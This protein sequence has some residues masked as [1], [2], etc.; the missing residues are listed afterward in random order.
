MRPVL[1]R[2][3]EGTATVVLRRAAPAWYWLRK[4]FSLASL[5][6]IVSIICGATAYI[7]VLQTRV[8]LVEHEV[9]TIEKIVPS[10]TVVSA[11]TST[12]TDHE[13]R[14]A[15]LEKNWDDA[16]QSAGSAPYPTHNRGKKP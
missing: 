14:I 1:P 5:L 7:W 15:R 4:N 12:V 11:L 13:Q 8:I 16:A 2:D 9:T 10:N 6:T 3:L